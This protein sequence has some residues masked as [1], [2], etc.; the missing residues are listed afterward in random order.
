MNYTYFLIN[1][2][3]HVWGPCTVKFH[4]QGEGRG[5]GAQ[6]DPCTER[7]H[8]LVEWGGGWAGLGWVMCMVRSNLFS[9]K[10]N[11]NANTANIF[12]RE[13]LV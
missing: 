5:A 4:V 6:K 7:S 9:L 10:Q 2:F 1:K 11:R 12:V 3:E 8:I 13:K